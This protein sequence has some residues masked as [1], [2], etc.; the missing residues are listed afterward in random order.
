MNLEI[1]DLRQM[2]ITSSYSVQI[3][4]GANID[5][6]HNI[7]E[8]VEK[9]AIHINNEIEKLENLRLDILDR[10]ANINNQNEKLILKLRYVNNLSFNEIAFKTNYSVS[11]VFN[12]HKKALVNF[13]KNNIIVRCLLAR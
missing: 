9:L 12:V 6:I 5:K 11:M 7:C 13:E 4:S 10:I 8:K 1:K 3:S 2:N